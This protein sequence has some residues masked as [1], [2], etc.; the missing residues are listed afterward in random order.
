MIFLQFN[1]YN[2]Y[3]INS[4]QVIKAY[5]GEEVEM[6][7]FW[8]LA[9]DSV[10]GELHNLANFTHGKKCPTHTEEENFGSHSRFGKYIICLSHTGINPRFLRCLACIHVT[11]NTFRHIHKVVKSDCKLHCVCLP[12]SPYGTTWLPVDRFHEILFSGFLLKS[13]EKIQFW[14]Q[15]DKIKRHF[16]WKHIFVTFH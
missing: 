3:S 11:I 2:T 10:S 12:V 9:L 1:F 5:V 8:A 6:H 16:T 7:S 4:V 14:L 13:V 15:S